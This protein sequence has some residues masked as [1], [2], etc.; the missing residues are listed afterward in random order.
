M[1][2]SAH[3]LD[4]TTFADVAFEGAS[5]ADRARV[6]D[7]ALLA[8]ATRGNKRAF[9]QLYDR[10]IRPV[11]AYVMVNLEDRNDAEEVIQ[12]AFVALWQRRQS[13][14]IVGESVLPW[15]LVTCKNKILNRR[16]AI[17]VHSRRRSGTAINETFPSTT[18]GPEGHAQLAELQQFID[19]AV[20]TLSDPD[21]SVFE[22]CIVEG[23]SYD[24]T[25]KAIGVSTD[26]IRNRLSRLR[27]HLRSEL[28]TLRGTQ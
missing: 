6:T 25:A 3:Y 2:F 23:R 28:H 11:H 7:V 24:D 4:M 8:G 26:A 1:R 18:L 15:L 16:R 21:R 17:D 19:A 12:D 5:S 10:H 20:A 9:E 22:L 13:I 27:R 14:V